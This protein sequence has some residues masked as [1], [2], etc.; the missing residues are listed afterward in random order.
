MSNDSTKV[1]IIED[2]KPIQ[3]LLTT[4]LEKSGFDTIAF[5]DGATAL[6]WLKSNTPLI[7][8][9]DF[10]LPDLDGGAIVEFIRTLPNGNSIPVIA[11][12]GLAQ[13]ND[14][15][16]IMKMGFDSYISKPIQTA[17]FANQIKDLIEQKK[18]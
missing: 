14:R 7:V 11:V 9:A 18:A 2:N 3:K 5:G 1:C 6:D 8:L 10:V 16:K 15:E 13:E 12:T 17:T 4:I